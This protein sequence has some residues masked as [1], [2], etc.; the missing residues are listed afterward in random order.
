MNERY[1]GI[2]LP[3]TALPSPYGVGSFGKEARC[4]IDFLVKSGQSLWQVLP[5]V[6]T[7]YGDSPYSSSC[8]I[9]GSP[10]LIDID[11]LIEKGL[12]TADEAKEYDCDGGNSRVNYEAL[13]YRRIPLLKI[14]FSRFDKADPDFLS[15]INKGDYSDFATFMALKEAHGWRAL[16]TWENSYRTRD[17]E[18]MREFT[19]S[20]E[21]DILF[22]HFTQYEF[23][24][25]W[26]ELKSYANEHGVQIMGDMPLYVSEDSAEVWAHP[27]LFLLNE[28]G[29][30]SE[31]AGVPPDYFS[32]DGQLWGNPL[33]NWDRM[34]EDGY[35]WWTARL[36]S[37]LSIYDIVRIDHFRGFDRFYAVPA[38]SPNAR[39]GRW[40]DGPKEALFEDKKDWKIVSEDLGVLDEGVYRLMRN[41]GY[42]R[43]KILEFAF[44]GNPTHEFKPSNY[45]ENSVVYTG[46]HDNATFIEFL[47]DMDIKQRKIFYG[48]LASECKRWGVAFRSLPWQHRSERTMHRAREAVIQIAYLSRAKYVIFPLQDILG[49]GAESRMNMPGTLG[50]QN[51]SWRYDKQSLSDSLAE[52]IAAAVKRGAR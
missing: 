45:G 26:S 25:Q 51:W 31:V 36:K 4:F 38:G 33:Y 2:L 17:E 29:Y 7:G 16:T 23:F 5:L 47:R 9:A 13:F 20:H 49:T 43:M 6:P 3:I 50:I 12:L 44:D 48:D 21:D 14:A 40:C 28:D 1:A 22:W 11:I 39:I 27:E 41:T 52:K 30:P 19:L 24:R 46:T 42:P 37:A 18:A 35:A 34:K 10:Y 32:E 15:F 8:A